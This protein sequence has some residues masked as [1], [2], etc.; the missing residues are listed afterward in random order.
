MNPG[1]DIQA[2]AGLVKELAQARPASG[3]QVRGPG[4]RDGSVGSSTLFVPWQL[5][6]TC[7]WAH[8]R[9]QPQALS[10]EP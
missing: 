7:P 5:A 4:L 10:L 8:N 6:T 1:P 2:L 3:R 9:E